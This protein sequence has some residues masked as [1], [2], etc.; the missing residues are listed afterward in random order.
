MLWRFKSTLRLLCRPA[1]HRFPTPIL[2][3]S[4]PAP[5]QPVPSDP[6]ICQ[7][8][9]FVSEFGFYNSYFDLNFV[10]FNLIEF[11]DFKLQSSDSYVA[12]P[13]KSEGRTI[14]Y[15][16]AED[17]GDVDDEA[18]Q[19]Y[20]MTFKGNGVDELTRKLEEETGIEGIIVCARSPL[21]QQLFPLR[22]QLPPNNVTMQVVLV[23][24]DSKGEGLAFINLL[25]LCSMY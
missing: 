3:T 13:P 16:I 6:A 12:S 9:R 18:V 21:N 25:C 5:H 7:D 2:W 8:K 15:H 17:N 11:D 20:S 19:G 1:R 22:L 10:R 23:L 14:Y 4:N 24:P